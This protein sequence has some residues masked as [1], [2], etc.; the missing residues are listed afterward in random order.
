MLGPLGWIGTWR[1]DASVRCRCIE[2]TLPDS[3]NSS[4]DI[5]IDGMSRFL[6]LAWRGPRE[7]LVVVFA[8]VLGFV[9]PGAIL[10]MLSVHLMEHA[11]LSDAMLG[12]YV[13][14]D[15]I[16]CVASVLIFSGPSRRRHSSSHNEADC[17]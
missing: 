8:L 10:N 17:N 16:G 2:H 14:V 5:C 11:F 1:S 15:V 3:C 7:W 9:L 12:V 13:L 6:L 4:V